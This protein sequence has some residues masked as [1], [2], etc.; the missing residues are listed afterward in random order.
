MRA[1][2]R[3]GMHSCVLPAPMSVCLCVR[4]HQLLRKPLCLRRRVRMPAAALDSARPFLMG[5]T[6]TPAHIGRVSVPA[7][8][9]DVLVGT[10]ASSLLINCWHYLLLPLDLF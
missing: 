10:F 4:V 7:Q 2:V 3:A 1:S 5:V 8:T 6:R 9:L